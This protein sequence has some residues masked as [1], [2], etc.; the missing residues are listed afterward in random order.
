MSDRGVSANQ[1]WLSSL[2]GIPITK[3]LVDRETLGSFYCRV[4]V[5]ISAGYAGGFP[6]A[7]QL[8]RKPSFFIAT[9]DSGEVVYQN[10]ADVA[11]SSGTT[12]YC[13]AR[14]GATDLVSANVT[15]L[16]A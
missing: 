13:R 16:V 5:Y 2:S 12:F 6:V 1:A 11:A 4:G 10:P 7:I 9:T 8:P 14:L 3:A 15:L